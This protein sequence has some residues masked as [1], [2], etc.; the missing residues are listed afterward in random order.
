MSKLRVF[1]PAITYNAKGPL[2]ADAIDIE[3]YN[4]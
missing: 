4:G 1:I 3:V 2:R